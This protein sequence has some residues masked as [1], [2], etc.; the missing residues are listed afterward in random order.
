MYVNYRGIVRP[1]KV[2]AIRI[3]TK[4]NNHRIRV[5]GTFHLS[6]YYSHEYKATFTFDSIGKSLFY[7]DAE[8]KGGLPGQIS[9]EED[10]TDERY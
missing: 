2:K 8:A 10:S 1:V 4:K 3:D 6:E 7:T 5:W 9:I